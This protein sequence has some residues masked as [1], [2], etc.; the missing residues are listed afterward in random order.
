MKP[1][2]KDQT[3]AFIDQL[4]NGVREEIESLETN[5]V[6]RKDVAEMT[7]STTNFISSFMKNNRNSIKALGLQKLIKMASG[8][9]LRVKLIITNSKKKEHK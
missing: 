1:K 8:L 7:A 4:E 3:P 9:G 5:G 2:L 6:G